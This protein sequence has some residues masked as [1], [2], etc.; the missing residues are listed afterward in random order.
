MTCVIHMY[1]YIKFNGNLSYLRQIFFNHG[2]TLL[3]SSADNSPQEQ[4]IMFVQ[5][6][7]LRLFT[8]SDRNLRIREKRG[9]SAGNDR[10]DERLE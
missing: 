1:A 10:R 5:K 8:T 6:F 2:R 7:P 4:S 9:G 3:K